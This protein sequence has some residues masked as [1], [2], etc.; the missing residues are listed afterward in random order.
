MGKRGVMRY[1]EEVG[2]GGNAL[3][4]WKGRYRS[5][6]LTGGVDSVGW[7]AP[8][9]NRCR[10]RVFF[11]CL[12]YFDIFGGEEVVESW[13]G[14]LAGGRI[15][16][17]VTNIY[18]YAT[19]FE[20]YY[21]FSWCLLVVLLLLA[22]ACRFRLTVVVFVVF[23]EGV[24]IFCPSV[25]KG[26]PNR[27]SPVFASLRARGHAV[28]GGSSQD[29]ITTISW[30]CW[31]C[32]LFFP[33]YSRSLWIT[34]EAWWFW[35]IPGHCNPNTVVRIRTLNRGDVKGMSSQLEPTRCLVTCTFQSVGK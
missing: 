1:P 5:A 20:H 33:E 30:A 14:V 2:R 32:C 16:A 21:C 23:V 4:A 35:R 12:N 19:R 25:S 18:I 6:R 8:S 13:E 28:S 34:G 17:R 31:G 3:F 15:K 29:T 24:T 22:A 9:F 10:V 11:Y 26:L 27:P 7:G